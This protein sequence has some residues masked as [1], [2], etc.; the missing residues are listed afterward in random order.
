[1]SPICTTRIAPVTRDQTLVKSTP[2]RKKQ[3]GKWGSPLGKPEPKK[4]AKMANDRKTHGS[5][6]VAA[7]DALMLW[8]RLDEDNPVGPADPT[9]GF[10]Q[11]AQNLAKRGRAM[12]QLA[13]E[14]T[15]ANAQAKWRSKVRTHTNH[16]GREEDLYD[17]YYLAVENYKRRRREALQ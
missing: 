5:R 8:S 10:S 16:R 3:K 15:T 13:V 17:G 2:V 1:M 9:E 4:K 6:V 7:V 14:T 11:D 12:V